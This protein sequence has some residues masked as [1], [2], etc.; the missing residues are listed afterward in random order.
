MEENYLKEVTFKGFDVDIFKEALVYNVRRLED[1][2][3]EQRENWQVL[4]L[5]KLYIEEQTRKEQIE[6]K[7][8]NKL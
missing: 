7:K 4:V 6:L 8:D 3:E 2:A 1:K 5:V